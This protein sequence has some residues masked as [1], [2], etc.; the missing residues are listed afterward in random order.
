MYARPFKTVPRS[1][2]RAG[3]WKRATRYQLR[4]SLPNPQPAA[5]AA[6]SVPLLQFWMAPLTY[7][8]TT[9]GSS[10][11]SGNSQQGGLAAGGSGGGGGSSSS[12]SSSS[13]SGSGSGSGNGGGVGA[14]HI[15]FAVRGSKQGTMCT[16]RHTLR[17]ALGVAALF[18]ACA[19]VRARGLAAAANSSSVDVCLEALRSAAAAI[20]AAA[21]PPGALALPPVRAASLSALGAVACP[22]GSARSLRLGGDCVRCGNGTALAPAAGRCECWVGHEA[23]LAG[24]IACRG[25]LSPGRGGGTGSAAEVATAICADFARARAAL[26][27]GAAA[28][29]AAARLAGAA[30]LRRARGALL[31]VAGLAAANASFWTELDFDPRLPASPTR[32]H[33]VAPSCS[34]CEGGRFEDTYTRQRVRGSVGG[35]GGPR[36]G[37]GTLIRGGAGEGLSCACVRG[38]PTQNAP[39]ARFRACNCL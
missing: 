9:S 30:F 36:T 8:N 10:G 2:E 12:S 4:L 26:A 23:A 16:P 17:A 19:E 5:A 39:G 25:A 33:G 24:D 21:A 28:D 27:G 13:G 32:R 1:F 31:D 20:P 18:D 34:R 14:G 29:R 38:S 6:S 3:A 22:P 15:A 37:L 7:S 11:A 35:C